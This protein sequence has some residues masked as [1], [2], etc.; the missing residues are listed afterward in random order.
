MDYHDILYNEAY[1]NIT[2]KEECC[3]ILSD[4]KAVG[5]TDCLKFLDGSI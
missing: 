1:E 5:I 3:N 2:I 4:I